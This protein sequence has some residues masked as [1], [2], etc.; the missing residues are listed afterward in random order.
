MANEIPCVFEQSR[1]DYSHLD[2]FSHATESNPQNIVHCLNSII[3]L[4]VFRFN[5]L[6]KAVMENTGK[7]IDVISEPEIQSDLDRINEKLN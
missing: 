6:D 7:I 2:H 3:D 5:K 1:R 4:I